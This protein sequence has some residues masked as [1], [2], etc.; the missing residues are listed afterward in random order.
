ML[1][2]DEDANARKWLQENVANRFGVDINSPMTPN[3]QRMVTQQVII[4]LIARMLRQ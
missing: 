3:E 1:T 4:E 2:A